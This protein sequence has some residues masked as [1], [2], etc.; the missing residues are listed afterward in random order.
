[1]LARITRLFI[2]VGVSIGFFF[3]LA[4]YQVLHLLVKVYQLFTIE[5]TQIHFL[6]LLS[7]G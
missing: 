6:W 7:V 4:V 2:L 1:M 5:D 3:F